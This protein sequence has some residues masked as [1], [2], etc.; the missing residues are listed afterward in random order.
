MLESKL[1][2]LFAFVG[3]IFSMVSR[4]FVASAVAEPN[5]IS[6]VG[7]HETWSLIF[8][9]DN[10]SIRTIKKS[11]LQDD[12]FETLAYDRTFLLY[13]KNCEYISIFRDDSVFLDW[14]LE[15]FA[16]VSKVEF[17]L[18]MS[19]EGRYYK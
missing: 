11:V 4:M 19:T 15:V 16:V 2:K 1:P 10:P 7:K 9:I 18:G 8:V 12:G 17:G 14:I 3:I 5:I 13:P 6:F